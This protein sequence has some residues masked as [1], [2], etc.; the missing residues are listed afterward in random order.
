[1]NTDEVVKDMLRVALQQSQMRGRPFLCY[2]IEM[3]L[4]EIAR[5]EQKQQKSG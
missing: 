2:L 5:P 4:L 3:A 1:M